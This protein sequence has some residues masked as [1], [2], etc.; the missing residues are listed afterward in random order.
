MAVHGF[1]HDVGT[2]AGEVDGV[3]VAVSVGDAWMVRSKGAGLGEELR[4][5]ILR[6]C[7]RFNQVYVVEC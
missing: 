2:H 4:K 1:A 5:C 3:V 6:E 7:S